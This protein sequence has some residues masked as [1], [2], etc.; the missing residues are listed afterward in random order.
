[1][2]VTFTPTRLSGTVKAPPSKSMGH[3]MLISAGLAE[4][5]STITGISHSQDMLATM[6][7]LQGLGAVCSRRAEADSVVDVQGSDP[8]CAA[9]ETPLNCRDVSKPI[10]KC[11]QSFFFA[12]F[13]FVFF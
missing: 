13:G 10:G 11:L 12:L 5:Q 8:T 2:T 4:G 1:M 6:E 7:L 9:P 3:R